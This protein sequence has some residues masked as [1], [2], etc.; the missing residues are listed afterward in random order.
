MWDFIDRCR[1]LIQ[2]CRDHYIVY[3]IRYIFFYLLPRSRVSRYMN[4]LM[5]AAMESSLLLLAVYVLCVTLL[6]LAYMMWGLYQQTLV[7]ERF[8]TTFHDKA[9]A[10]NEIME[11]DFWYF[12]K[13]ITLSAFLICIG[14]SAVGWFLP[15]CRFFYL[16]QGFF[17]KLIFWGL[18]LSA[19]VACYIQDTFGFSSLEMIFIV[20]V[21]PT[22]CLFMSCFNHTEKLIPGLEEIISFLKNQG[23]LLIVYI[24]K[25][26]E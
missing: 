25:R 14:I 17:G 19:I 8:L 1:E 3:R 24:K 7:G 18:P 6:Y 12:S 13:D 10:I 26:S 11:L 15:V 9:F 5:S 2:R 16:S 20:S 4:I 21:I 22:C 23:R